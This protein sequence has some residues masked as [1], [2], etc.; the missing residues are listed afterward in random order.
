M[1]TVKGFE[2]AV[3]ENISQAFT[4]I[5]KGIGTQGINPYILTPSWTT[6]M[7]AL[8]FDTHSDPIHIYDTRNSTKEINIFMNEANTATTDLQIAPYIEELEIVA[9]RGRWDLSTEKFTLSSDRD[10]P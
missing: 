5:D 8:E 1:E 4:S 10:K 9:Q 7:C 6:C 3:Q 2:S